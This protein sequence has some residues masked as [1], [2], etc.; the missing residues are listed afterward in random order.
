MALGSV[1]PASLRLEKTL[2]SI[3]EIWARSILCIF[4]G[5]TDFH[6][7]SL[8]FQYPELIGLHIKHCAQM[9]R[10]ASWLPWMHLHNLSVSLHELSF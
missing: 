10:A 5:K 1:P 4:L 7:K 8:P 9:M 3:A 2:Y 6:K